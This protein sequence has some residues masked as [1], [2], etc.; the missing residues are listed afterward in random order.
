MLHARILLSLDQFLREFFHSLSYGWV[1][2]ECFK[3]SAVFENSSLKRSNSATRLP[4]QLLSRRSG[5]VRTDAF[6]DF[7][8]CGTNDLRNGGGAAE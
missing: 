4:R 2:L 7:G 8:T 5:K 1:C 6:G 3:F